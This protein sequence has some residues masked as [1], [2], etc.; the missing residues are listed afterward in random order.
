MSE[1]RDLSSVDEV[2]DFAIEKES[3]AA[4]FYTDWSR[5]V[6]N[7]SIGRV[8][9]EF[10]EEERKHQ[11]YITDV[12]NGKQIPESPKDVT[13]LSISDYLVETSPSENMDYQTTL[14]VA[15]QREK[16]AFRLYTKLASVAQNE[17]VQKLFLTLAQDEARHKLRL[18]TI[19][20]D[21]ILRDN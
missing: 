21:E 20:D 7:K 16:S 14:M 11:A 3:E 1:P 17:H 6:E 19:Y 5:T 15:M 12:K 9:L 10:A 18:E 8:L 4:A 2:L 13:D